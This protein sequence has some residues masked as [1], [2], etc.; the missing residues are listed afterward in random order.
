MPSPVAKKMARAR[1]S[2][3]SLGAQL[4]EVRELR[5]LT[6]KQVERK[7]GGLLDRSHL[8]RIENGQRTNLS[9]ATL[10]VLCVAYDM[11]L[12][13]KRDGSIER[14]GTKLGQ[15]AAEARKNAELLA[16]AEATR[17]GAKA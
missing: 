17:K 14:R 6:M 10:A 8:S 9:L 13:L 7:T 11:D 15:L 2:A 3:E 1:T 12:L 5:G 4:R 16:R